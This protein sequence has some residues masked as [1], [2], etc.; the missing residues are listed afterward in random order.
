MKKFRTLWELFVIFLKIGTFCFGGGLAMLPLIQKEVVD[1]KKWLNDEEIVD[2]F[3]ISQS[4][5]GVIAVNSAAIVGKKVMGIWGACIATFAV[6]LPAFVSVIIVV[7]LLSFLNGNIYVQKVFLGIKAAS[8][9]LIL[10]VA[11]KLGKSAIKGK[12][13]F[14]IAAVSFVIIVIFNVFAAWAVV[15]GG[16]A[17]YLSYLYAYKNACKER[18]K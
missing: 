10:M 6:I 18:D 11:I 14:L 12:L 8:A 9:A 2:A 7:V 13:G 16:V 15:F 17:G 4:L 1:K 5:P 3:A